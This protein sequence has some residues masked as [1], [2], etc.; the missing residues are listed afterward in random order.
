MPGYT[1]FTT[2]FF[3]FFCREGHRWAQSLAVFV[4]ES[5]PAPY[6]STPDMRV[7]LELL[8]NGFLVL[9]NLASDRVSFHIITFVI[10]SV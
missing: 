8:F 4:A 7:Y 2:I 3:F 9:Q 1:L 6:F 10:A 5:L